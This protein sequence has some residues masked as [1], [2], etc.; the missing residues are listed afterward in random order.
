[1]NLFQRSRIIM[2]LVVSLL[3][4]PF[5]SWL[6][7]PGGRIPGQP[8][9]SWLHTALV[10]LAAYAALLLAAPFLLEHGLRGAAAQQ[11]RSRGKEPRAVILLTAIVGTC[12]LT[13]LAFFLV[14][15]GGPTL[16]VY[17]T[18]IVAEASTVYWAWCYRDV[19]ADSTTAG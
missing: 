1:M 11:V 5:F 18:S 4:P 14:V 16:L 7:S 17:V 15:A 10:V 13:P 6:V 12:G 9:P 19:L 2:W 8:E 3:L